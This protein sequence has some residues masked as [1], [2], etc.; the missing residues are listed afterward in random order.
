MSTKIK[1]KLKEATIEKELAFKVDYFI[2]I[3]SCFLLTYFSNDFY[4]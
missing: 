1:R 2:Y 4:I 3:K